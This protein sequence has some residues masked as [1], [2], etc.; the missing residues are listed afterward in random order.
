MRVTRQTHLWNPK[1]DPEDQSGWLEL[2]QDFYQTILNAPVPVD[3][4][5]LKVLNHSPLALDLYAWSTHKAYSTSLKNK[6]VH[7]SYRELQQQLGAQYSELK[8]FGRKLRQ[9]LTLVQTVYPDL[10]VRVETGGIIICPSQP[11]VRRRLTG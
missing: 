8:A 5:A 3:R 2:T 6:E 11:A 7:F 10:E 9:A 1:N 4:R